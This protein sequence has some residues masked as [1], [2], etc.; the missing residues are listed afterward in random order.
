[1][2]KR[3]SKVGLVLLLA[4]AIASPV[5]AQESAEGLAR[6]TAAESEEYSNSVEVLLGAVTEA[7]SGATA[8]ALGF[9]YLRD[10]SGDLKIAFVVEFAA[11]DVR[12]EGLILMPFYVNPTGGLLLGM[13][14][15]I[16]GLR[17]TG[18]DGEEETTVLLAV[19]FSAAWEFE[20]GRRFII[21]PEINMDVADGN[22]TWVYGVALGWAF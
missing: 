18:E 20:I 9:G 21:A 4:L 16:E 15:G 1:M 14:P 12:R 13:G 8:F 7:G 11:S 22:G 10:I 5:L 6:E 17:E 19:R 2:M 3:A